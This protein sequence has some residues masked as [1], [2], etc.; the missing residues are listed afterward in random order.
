MEAMLVLDTDHVYGDIPPEAENCRESPRVRIAEEGETA[1]EGR[2]RILTVPLS[3]VI[4]GLPS[5]K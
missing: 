3:V 1:T 2:A 5:L 4:R